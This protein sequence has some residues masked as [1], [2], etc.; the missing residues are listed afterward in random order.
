M[1]VLGWILSG[2][3]AAFF[4][5]AGFSKLVTSR[6]KLLEN[7]N[8]AW[9]ND[10]SQSQ[11]RAISILEVIGGLGVVLPWLVD[12]APVLTPIAAIGCGLIMVGAI[13][14]HLRR[15]ERTSLPPAVVALLLA[16]AVAVIRFS[17]L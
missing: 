10:F 1:A 17:Q 3:L 16:V 4:L 5:G 12:V 11:V 8:M 13:A 9:V 7:P 2:A 6:D 15:H 14:V